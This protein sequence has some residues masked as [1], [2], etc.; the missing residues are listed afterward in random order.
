MSWAQGFSGLTTFQRRRAV[1]RELLT[2]RYTETNALL[3]SCIRN[4]PL[5]ERDES[6]LIDPFY[7]IKPNVLNVESYLVAKAWMSPNDPLDVTA[8]Q[9]GK[10]SPLQNCTQ[11][12]GLAA[13]FAVLHAWLLDIDLTAHLQQAPSRQQQIGQR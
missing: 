1:N 4:L 9:T 3:P 11:S 12:S 8:V 13:L 10:C 6:G 2:G 7:K 5:A